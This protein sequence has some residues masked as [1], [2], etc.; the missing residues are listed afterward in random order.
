MLQDR[1]R[2]ER[3][4]PAGSTQLVRYLSISRLSTSG[5]CS[6]EAALHGCA[7]TTPLV[8]LCC[9]DPAALC[10]AKGC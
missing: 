10:K 2:S 8:A 1:L 3:S 9:L 6:R 7:T 4:K 5:A